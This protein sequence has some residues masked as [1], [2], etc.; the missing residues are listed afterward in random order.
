MRRVATAVGLSRLQATVARRGTVRPIRDVPVVAGLR[1]A[2]PPLGRRVGAAV[3]RG[4][5]LA[6]GRLATAHLACLH[7]SPALHG[8]RGP[9]GRHPRVAVPLDAGLA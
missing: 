6:V 4:Q 8:T 1:V 7:P 3:Q 9:V 2:P 5:D